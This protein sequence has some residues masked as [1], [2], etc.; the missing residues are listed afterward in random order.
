MAAS[1]T[2]TAEGRRERARKAG[3][4]SQSP[5]TYARSLA[6]RWPALTEEQR[7]EVRAHLAPVLAEAAPDGGTTT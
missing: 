7:A 6:A 5:R 1:K 4:A 3:L 2:L